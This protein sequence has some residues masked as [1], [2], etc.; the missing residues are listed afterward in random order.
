MLWTNVLLAYDNSQT[1]LRAVEYVGQMFSK[2][3]GVKVTLFSVYDKVP[4][5]DMVDTHFTKQVKGNIA[6]LERE[7]ESGRLKMDEAK[8][9]LLRLGFS[10]DQVQV[11]YIEKEKSIPK[12]IIDEVNVG[13]YGTV[14]VGRRGESNIKNML[15][16]SVSG[17]VISNLTG[18]TICVVE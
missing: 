12:Q 11:K 8:N 5:Y 2:V 14:V 9:H 13:Q 6:A 1:A 18:A 15:F 17:S 3:E 16:G 7:K 10:E 4:D